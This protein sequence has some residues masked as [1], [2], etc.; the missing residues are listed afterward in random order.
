MCLCNNVLIDAPV[1][2]VSLMALVVFSGDGSV[3]VLCI[4][5]LPAYTECVVKSPVTKFCTPSTA[6]LG[7]HA[8]TNHRCTEYPGPELLSLSLHVSLWK[9][10]LSRRSVKELLAAMLS[11]PGD[12]DLPDVVLLLSVVPSGPGQ[13]VS[14]HFPTE[15]SP[16]SHRCNLLPHTCLWLLHCLF[17]LME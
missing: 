14:P 3:A 7:W 16:S 17:P 13:A 6:C 1:P 9:G 10:P 5:V 8:K 2:A 15:P 11:T 4:H 12:T